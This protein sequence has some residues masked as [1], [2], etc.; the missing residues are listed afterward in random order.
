MSSEPII[1]FK[2]NKYCPFSF[3]P[4]RNWI[5]PFQD[6]SSIDMATDDRKHA[7]QNDGN[8]YGIDYDKSKENQST[9]AENDTCK[10]GAENSKECN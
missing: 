1:T 9:D 7:K 3:A 6:F 10:V 4:S 5:I 2:I 8:D